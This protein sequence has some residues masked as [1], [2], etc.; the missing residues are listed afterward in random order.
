M[1]TLNEFA[2]KYVEPIFHAK[3]SAWVCSPWISKLYAEKLYDL[4]RKGVEVR[5]ITS[6][7]EYNADTYSY[8]SQ[9]SHT[10]NFDVHFIK[11]EAV[12]SK[13]YVIDDNYAITGAVNF[14]Y[15]GLN[16]QTNNFTIYENQEVDSIAKD[17][18]RLWIGYKSERVQPTQSTVTNILPISP[19]EKAVIPEITNPDVIDVSSAKLTINPYYVIRYSLLENVKLPWYQQEVVEDKG[20]VVIDAS[21]SELLNYHSPRDYKSQMIIRDLV[22]VSPIKETVIDISEKYSLENREWDV[23]IDGYKAE[24][25]AINYIKEI[26]RRDIPYNDRREGEKYQPYVPSHRAITILS[27][28]LR[29]VPTWHFQYAFKDKTHERTLLASSGEVLETSFHE[30]GAVCEDCGKSISK[31]DARRC[32]S[33]NKWLCPSERIDCSSCNG[34]FHKEHITKICAI[35][36]QLTCDQCIRKCPICNKEYGKDHV[37]NC[38]DCGVGICPN[39]IITSG[40]LL[41]KNRCPSCEEKERRKKNA[42]VHVK[43]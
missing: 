14:T 33:C 29:L 30:N 22:K 43:K 15:T 10:T 42:K 24:A 27:N 37:V 12:H 32:P 1:R 36:H 38:R 40:L 23:K 41:K 16:K 9:L 5:I 21:N 13:I 6:D 31:E 39:C 4:S 20:T 19:Y 28:D 8:L 2:W 25:L 34:W 26:N 3:K 17:F 18:M 35:Y 11:K 7:D